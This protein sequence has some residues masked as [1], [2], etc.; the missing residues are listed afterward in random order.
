MK[1]QNDPKIKLSFDGCYNYKKLKEDIDL[2]AKLKDI[3][4]KIKEIKETNQFLVPRSI[5]YTYPN[6]G[7]HIWT[8]PKE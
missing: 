1:K 2:T 4:T 5:R 3:E 7:H 8:F 6:I